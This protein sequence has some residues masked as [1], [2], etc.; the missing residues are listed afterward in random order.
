MKKFVAAALTVAAL[1]AGYGVN[2][3]TH[4]STPLTSEL[5]TL[6]ESQTDFEVR[7]PDHCSI[8]VNRSCT[9][10]FQKPDHCTFIV[11]ERC[12]K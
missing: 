3:A 12:T 4:A 11:N 7:G 10:S 5:V 1:A 8:I 6:H 9:E 2:T